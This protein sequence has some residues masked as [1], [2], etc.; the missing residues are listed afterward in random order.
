MTYKPQY[1]GPDR[2]LPPRGQ[3]S[4]YTP[5][6]E[7]HRGPDNLPMPPT[8][9][10]QPVVAQAPGAQSG[11]Q[12]RGQQP[13]GNHWGGHYSSVPFAGSPQQFANAAPGPGAMAATKPVIKLKAWQ[14]VLL[15]I[16]V[17][18][19][20]SVTAYQIAG[21]DSTST[22]AKPKA[23]IEV[24]TVAVPS[25]SVA[26]PTIPTYSSPDVKKLLGP[27][28]EPKSPFT[29]GNIIPIPEKWVDKVPSFVDKSMPV[30]LFTEEL[31]YSLEVSVKDKI[32]CSAVP[33]RYGLTVFHLVEGKE[34]VAE[35]RHAADRKPQADLEVTIKPGKSIKI[36]DMPPL[37]YVVHEI[38]EEELIVYSFFEIAG[39][40]DIPG[41]LRSEG[42]AE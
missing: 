16:V 31:T 39:E 37:K 35:V 22:T 34:A 17:V 42:L 13:D 23:S 30:C 29:D 18:T 19:I 5:V 27:D 3:L 41:F 9:S 11:L 24:P 1:F 26:V 10:S 14:Q 4:S 2:N 15:G 33:T 20:V 7:E 32:G 21:P 6:S 38:S 28:R 25:V 8:R 36:L 40:L 12:P